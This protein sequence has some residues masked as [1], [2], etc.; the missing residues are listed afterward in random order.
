MGTAA[1]GRTFKAA[2]GIVVLGFL[3]SVM[4]SAH[5]Q[6]FAREQERLTIDELKHVYLTC[7]RTAASGQL[8]TGRIQYCSIVYEELKQ[9]A[10]GGDFDRLLAWSSA[11]PSAKEGR[12]FDARE[13]RPI[14]E[15]V[16]GPPP[17][18]S[19]RRDAVE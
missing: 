15:G 2:C 10:F 3:A 5:S 17:M 9:R 1:P 14:G 18:H 13:P 12:T 7:N 16:L 11:N 4:P 19:G 8:N 6:S